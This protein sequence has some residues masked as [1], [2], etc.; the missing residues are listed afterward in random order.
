M[1]KEEKPPEEGG[2]ANTDTK[3]YLLKYCFGRP[4]L[5]LTERQ[6]RVYCQMMEALNKYPFDLKPF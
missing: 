6:T 1:E 4:A 2:I 3:M 5:L